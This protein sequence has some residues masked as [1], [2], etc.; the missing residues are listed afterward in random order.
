MIPRENLMFENQ[1]Q[2]AEKLIEILPVSD[3]KKDNYI[4]IC[5]SLDS[6]I[7][8]DEIA[9]K[10]K[11]G[12]EILFS[13]QIFAPNNP[14]CAIACVSETQ[15]IV[16]MDELVKSFGINLDYIYGQSNRK[17]EEKIL[18]SVYKYR[19]GE[20]LQDFENR[21]VI[22]IDEGCESGMTA[23][24]CI[25]S[26]TNLNAKTII[27]AT[28]LIPNSV[29]K[30]LGVLVDELFC[31]HN[32]ADFVS[33]DFYYKEKIEPKVDIIMQILEESPYYLP[34]HKEVLEGEETNAVLS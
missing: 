17:Y 8:V 34:L 11:I 23:L 2:A 15:E 5:S 32:I 24:A 27:Y 9:R 18:K 7:L 16:I 14:E 21:N 29:A 4:I 30:N 10:L 13:E 28:P 1:I 31:V 19:K 26:L 25:K 12:Y 3:F 20:L 6:V 33:V 22:L